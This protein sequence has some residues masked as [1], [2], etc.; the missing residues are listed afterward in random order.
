M[1]IMASAAAAS[2]EDCENYSPLYQQL[3]T[4]PI[5]AEAFAHSPSKQRVALANYVGDRFI[6]YRNTDSWDIQFNINDVTIIINYRLIID[7]YN[8]IN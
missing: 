2:N 3:K 6:P 7:M 4:T 8:L 1:D 5:V